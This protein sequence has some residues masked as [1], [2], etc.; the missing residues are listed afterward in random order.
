MNKI[1]KVLA[2]GKT[3]TTFSDAGNSAHGLDIQLSS[4][5]NAKLAQ[6]SRPSCHTRPQSSCSPVPGRPATPPLSSWRRK[7]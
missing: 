5:G 4:P 6:N 2:T 7:T 1:E 3:H